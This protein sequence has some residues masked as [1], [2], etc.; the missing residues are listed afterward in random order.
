MKVFLVRH[1]Q[2]K[3]NV[4]NRLQGCVDIPLNSTGIKQAH[5]LANNIEDLNYDLIISSPLGRA[6]ETAK[7]INKKS[8]PLI[9]DPSLKERNFGFLEGVFGTDYDKNLYWDYNKNYKNK[10][11]EPI[12]EF[13]DRYSSSNNSG[14][15]TFSIKILS[16]KLNDFSTIILIIFFTIFI[17]FLKIFQSCNTLSSIAFFSFSG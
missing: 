3:W 4:E 6:L 13:F 5:I 7:I 9:T 14:I 8:A 12:Q 1:G 2:T 11:V 17:S 15:P 10:D 16:S